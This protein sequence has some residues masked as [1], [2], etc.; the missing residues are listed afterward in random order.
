MLSLK[1]IKIL[2]NINVKKLVKNM[3][4]EIFFKTLV[5]SEII[6]ILY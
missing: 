2:K 1:I 5:F 3:F 4:K 6:S